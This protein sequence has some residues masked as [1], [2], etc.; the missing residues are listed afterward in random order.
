MKLN[1]ISWDESW[2]PFHNAGND[3]EYTMSALKTMASG[4]TIDTQRE[5][6]WPGMSKGITAVWDDSDD[7][8]NGLP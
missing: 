2:A 4:P 6:R 3:A 5:E 8:Y 7:E 1:I